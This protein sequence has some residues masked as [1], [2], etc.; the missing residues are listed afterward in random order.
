[1]SGSVHLSKEINY[2][3]S[4]YHYN[5]QQTNASTEINSSTLEYIKA[6]TNVATVVNY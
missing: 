6:L 5:T 1:M 3:S 4:H 2:T